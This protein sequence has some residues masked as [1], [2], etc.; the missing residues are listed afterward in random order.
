MFEKVN[1]LQLLFLVAIVSI[2]S[3]A[4]IE[5]YVFAQNAWI[6]PDS[7]PGVT[8]NNTFVL[9]PLTDHLDI[10]TN[11]K[12]IVG[13]NV[14]L[15]GGGT[16]PAL[17]V[18]G[19]R[20]ICFN[21]TC[22]DDWPTVEGGVTASDG[23]AGYIPQFIS[24]NVIGNSKIREVSLNRYKLD[25][26]AFWIRNGGGSYNGLQLEFANPNVSYNALYI[27]NNSDG[28][29]GAIRIIDNDPSGSS[30]VNRNSLYIRNGTNGNSLY[31]NDTPNNY[32]A[33]PFVI[34]SS[35]RMGLG[36]TTPNPTTV[37]DGILHIQT[38]YN[39]A[40]LDIQSGWTN[41][42]WGIYQNLDD[43]A[44]RFWNYNDRLVID[45]DG[46]VGIGTNDPNYLLE[47][48][49]TAKFD[50]V[51]ADGSVSANALF[52]SK[53][54]MTELTASTLIAE[55]GLVLNTPS[56]TMNSTSGDSCKIEMI[57]DRVNPSTSGGGHFNITCY[58]PINVCGNS[59]VEPA[60]GEECDPVGSVRYS[61]NISEPG[62]YDC[63]AYSTF[64]RAKI[65]CQTSCL[66]NS[67]VCQCRF[68]C[69]SE[70]PP[71]EEYYVIDA[72]TTPG[73]TACASG[74]R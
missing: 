38:Q 44:L 71:H 65:S 59:I 53:G 68:R 52:A 27:T 32:N 16:D 25:N 23:T 10:G 54:F 5:R 31:I 62:L 15:D 66:E 24:E 17:T 49:G 36:T 58:A 18:S 40:E 67:A 48:I 72:C 8:P 13:D 28:D 22:L 64:S 56:I 51:L 9:N 35:G 19:G 3:V 61:Y 57:S 11:D 34:T 63:S 55:E 41:K 70:E 30:T 47:A 74:W 12:N 45:S 29:G 60:N 43:G 20:Q 1:N 7:L 42:H 33:T 50:G 6:D 4:L 73:P 21:G 14:L 46:N 26:G 69:I 2:F 39:N 37:S